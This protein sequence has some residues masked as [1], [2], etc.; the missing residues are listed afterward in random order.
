MGLYGDKKDYETLF[1]ENVNKARIL[2]EIPEQNRPKAIELLKQ[3]EEIIEKNG[4]FANLQLS[5]LNK[6]L[7]KLKNQ[8]K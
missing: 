4:F 1:K 7:E 6:E 5:K 3:K 8:N 2:Y